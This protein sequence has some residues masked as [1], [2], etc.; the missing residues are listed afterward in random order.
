MYH[1][2]SREKYAGKCGGYGG[3]VVLCYRHLNNQGR[4]RL[5]STPPFP[6]SYLNT[7]TVKKERNLVFFIV[8]VSA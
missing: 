7:L 2:V 4:Y 8:R 6:L 3:G 1:Y 5:M